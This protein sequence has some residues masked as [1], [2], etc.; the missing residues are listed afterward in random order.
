MK[1]WILM[2]L[3]IGYIIAGIQCYNV[4]RAYPHKTETLVIDLTKILPDNPYY[5]EY[6]RMLYTTV[7]I[8]TGL[9]TGSGVVIDGY[10]ITAAHVVD[11]ESAVTV[12][13]F[14]PE[15][16]KLDATVLV[17]DTVK[18][19]ALIKLATNAHES[20]QIYS[21]KLAPKDY[22]PYLFSP[23][24][25]VGCSLGLK[26]RPSYGIISVIDTNFWEVSSPILPGNSG[27]PVFNARTYEVIGI[28]VWVHIC[29]GQLVTTMAGIVPIQKIY[30]FL[31]SVESKESN[32]KESINSSNATD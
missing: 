3:A 28:S 29:N 14:F 26:V 30:E 11:N 17:T 22:T 16:I 19:L 20:T 15:Y 13:L 9:G 24:Y 2:V 27:G 5:Q 6:E 1:R 10:I 25:A 31:E 4:V 8:S 18:D 21:A 12:E 32:S 23:V 7:R